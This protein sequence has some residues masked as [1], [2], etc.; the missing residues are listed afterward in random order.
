MTGITLLIELLFLCLLHHLL[1]EFILAYDVTELKELKSL[2]QRKP[3][4][5]LQISQI[6]VEFDRESMGDF[7]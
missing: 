1:S 7:V 2:R 5:C 3:T 6:S 4:V